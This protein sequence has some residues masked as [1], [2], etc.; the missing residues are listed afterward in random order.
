MSNHA[1]GLWGYFGGTPAGEA[2]T[3]QATGMGGP[4]AAMVLAD[5]VELGVRRIVRVGTCVGRSR[6]LALGDLVLVEEAIAEGGS[7]ASLGIAAGATVSPDGPLTGRLREALGAD[8]RETSV[9][10]VDANPAEAASSAKIGAVDMQTAPLL[11]C[12][13]S[14]GVPAAAVLVVAELAGGATLDRDALESAE[15]RAGRAASAALSP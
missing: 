15:K 8:R 7:I 14:L 6:G 5:L 11:T 3:I 13:R 12:G 9:A 10:S 4:S 2:L 1:R